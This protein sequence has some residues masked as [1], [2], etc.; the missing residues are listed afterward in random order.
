MLY[1]F[2]F[3]IPI[4]IKSNKN[5]TKHVIIIVNILLLFDV[6]RVRFGMQLLNKNLTKSYNFVQLSLFLSLSLYLSV[7]FQSSPA[8]MASSR[9]R[10]NLTRNSVTLSP[11][12]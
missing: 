4:C 9:R 10:T 5:K 8:G 6:S 1:I 3:L 7:Y 12:S 11:L 2:L